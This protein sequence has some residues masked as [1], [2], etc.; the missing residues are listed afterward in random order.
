MVRQLG[1]KNV[2]RPLVQS[3]TGRLAGAMAASNERG[4]SSSVPAAS[5]PTGA[6]ISI[7]DAYMACP[8]Q[9]SS[10]TSS[11]GGPTRCRQRGPVRTRAGPVQ[12]RGRRPEHHV[13]IGM[14]S[15]LAVYDMQVDDS[16]LRMAL[17]P[18]RPQ[19]IVACG[20]T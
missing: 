5:F 1:A 9:C 4:Q 13:P 3:G 8:A 11:C 20:D 14:W 19:I 12:H 7:H 18:T 2:Q 16:V 6:L 15:C 17:R 10:W